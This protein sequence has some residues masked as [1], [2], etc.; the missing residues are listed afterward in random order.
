M[1]LPAISD[2]QRITSG[3]EVRM[4]DIFVVIGAII[5]V[6]AIAAIAFVIKK[7]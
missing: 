5:A 4:E 6:I 2:N 3:G 1:L 7:H